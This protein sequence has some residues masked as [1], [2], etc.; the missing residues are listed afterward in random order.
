[1]II[2]VLGS[3]CPKCKQLFENTKEAAN[4][5]GGNIEVMYITNMNEIMA[6]G[7]MQMP[8]LVINDKL[9]CTGRLLTPNEI[10]KLIGEEKR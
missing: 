9:K 8:A 10:S 3:G 7:I 1:M 5:F 2:K 4:K 6:S